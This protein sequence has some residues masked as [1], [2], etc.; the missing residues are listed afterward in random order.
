MKIEKLALEFV[1]V[2]SVALVTAAMV[3]LMWNIIG[4]AKSSINWETSFLFAFLFGIIQT[5]VKSREIK[6]K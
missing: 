6:A 4:H 5:W 3:T 1:T 2:F